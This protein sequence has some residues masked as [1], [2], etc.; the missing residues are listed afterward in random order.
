[1]K[2]KFN[3]F[4]VV[5]FA[6]FSFQAKAT[7]SHLCFDLFE[8]IKNSRNLDISSQQSYENSTFGFMPSYDLN[9]VD[10]KE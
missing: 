4:L 7:M 6:L 8:K 5:I 10:D 9:L 1:M 3:I 2:K